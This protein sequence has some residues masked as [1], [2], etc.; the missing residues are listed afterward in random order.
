MSDKL[1]PEPIGRRKLM[2]ILAGIPFLPV[3]GVLGMNSLNEAGD[4]PATHAPSAITDQLMQLTGKMQMGTLGNLTVSRMIMGCNPIIAWSHARDLLYPNRL[5][6]AYNTEDKIIET[7]H[8]GQQAGINTLVLTTEAYPVF[9]K[10]TQLYGDK[11]QTM[12]M[13]TMPVKDILSNIKMAVDNGADAIYIHGR[14]CDAYARSGKMDD[15]A[16]AIDYIRKQGLQ[17]GVGAH[18]LETIQKCEKD[19]FSSDFYFKTFHHDKYWSALPEEN[20]EP[21]IEIGPSY[22]D[23][24]KYCDNMWDLH[25]DRTV[26]FLKEVK[27]PVI[28]FK[29]LAAGA[30][31]PKVG[32]RYA[33][34]NGADF[35][36]VGMFDF[37]IVENVN[38]VC[39]I[40]EDIKDR[41]RKWYA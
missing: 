31:H 37:Q 25:P 29:V 6:K 18:C 17:A 9:N 38:T 15:L 22:V 3:P 39:Q 5:M 10:Y 12:C 41:Q 11:I 32:F 30:I 40:I 7:L 8:L 19:N 14:V 21:Y 27:K 24:N 23:H 33:F 13:A 34:E 28:G 2:K 16:K 1:T 36:C 26:E 4:L 20:R 35:I